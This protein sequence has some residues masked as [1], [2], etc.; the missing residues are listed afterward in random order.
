MKKITI[1]S[2][3]IFLISVVASAANAQNEDVTF[4][5]IGKHANFSQQSTGERLPIDY[6]FF[7]EVFM[8]AQG[9]AENASLILPTGERLEFEDMREAQDG[10]RDNIL[11]LAGEDR[12]T[13]L[14][15]LQARYPDGKF[16]VSFDTPSGNVEDVILEFDNRGLPVPPKISVTQA[17]KSHCTELLPS[18]NAVVDWDT[19]EGGRADPNGILDDLIF[20]ILTD[21]DENRIAHSGRPFEQTPYLNFA[22][23]SFTID[24][25]LL[26]AG[27][28]YTL[29]VEHA[30]LDDTTEFDNVPA[31]TTRAATTK[32]EISV[33]SDAA[34]NSE[35]AASTAIPSLDSQVTMLYYD[36]FDAAIQ[37][38]ATTL[39]LELEFDLPWIKFFKTGPSSSVGVVADSEGA[40]H[41]PQSTNAVMVSLVTRE[42][43][44]W[45]DRVKD[46][47]G[48]SFLKDIGDGGGIRSF[49]L[50]DPGGYTVE[51]FQWLDTQQ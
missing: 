10:S 23:R 41:T 43:D 31:F 8:K 6:S 20:V 45:H 48:V 5:V 39:G 2:C 14:T 34:E 4:F 24:G 36:D 49:I 7:S 47:S 21:A 32:L 18:V 38:Y 16:L 40:W 27:Q 12:F 50:E 25:D 3:I 33:F 30:I 13:E 22:A 1:P 9:N 29:S 26:Q 28:T 17:G 51:F 11:L 37:F 44:A 46:R 42:V 15:D 19:F 35:C